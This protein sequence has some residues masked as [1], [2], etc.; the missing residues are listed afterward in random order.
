[1]SRDSTSSSSTAYYLKLFVQQGDPGGHEWAWNTTSTTIKWEPT[2]PSGY[3][4]SAYTSGI[5]LINDTGASYSGAIVGGHQSVA[6]EIDIVEM[7]S[8]DKGST[9]Y[10]KRVASGI[11]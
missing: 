3:D 5:P 11:V 7:Y 8:L 10:A 4:G 1:M 2:Y 6:G 9:W